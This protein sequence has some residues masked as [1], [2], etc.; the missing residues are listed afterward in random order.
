MGGV[1][2]FNGL[3]EVVVTSVTLLSPGSAPRRADRSRWRSSAT[4]APVKR[5]KGNWSP[6]P[7]ST[8]SRAAFP[9]AGASGNVTVS[10]GTANIAL[11][12]DSD[13]D[14]DGTATPAGNFSV[15]ALAGQFD[16][17]PFDSGYQ[18]LPARAR[19]H[20]GGGADRDG[21]ARRPSTS[22]T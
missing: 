15:T 19:R 7:T 12:V 17:A 9:A 18:L 21:D 14:I 13:T 3:T 1:T 8:S 22:A 2:Q 4:A 20:R 11:R 6:S 5:S 16:V 10:D